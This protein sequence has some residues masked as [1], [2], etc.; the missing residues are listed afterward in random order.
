VEGDQLLGENGLSEPSEM[1][2]GK[3]KMEGEK[4][5]WKLWTENGS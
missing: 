5:K 2:G 1:E 4:G 3:G